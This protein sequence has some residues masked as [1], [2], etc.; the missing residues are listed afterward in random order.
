M[1]DLSHYEQ[2][3][4]AEEASFEEIQE[5]K[6][7][8]VSEADG[9]R[10]RVKL[11]ETAYDAILMERLRL[12]REGKI[13]VPERIRFAEE[14]QPSPAPA[15][16]SAP[17]RKFPAWLQRCIDTPSR[18]DILLPAAVFGGLGVLFL[19]NATV[20]PFSLALA[21]IGC[22][23]F[24]HRK[25]KKAARALF[26]SLLALIVGLVFG[27]AVA[28][29]AGAAPDGEENIIAFSWTVLVFFWATA[30]FLR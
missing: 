5:A 8:L 27:G 9:D 20:A 4:V 22:F 15:S 2:L 30:S 6:Q 19:F 18:Q 24:L 25:E 21:I 3:G 11:I 10:Q 28:T 17:G 1:R 7:R 23:Y 14:R 16:P 12:R 29:I 13:D 26:L